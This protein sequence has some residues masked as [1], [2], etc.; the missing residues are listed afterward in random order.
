MTGTSDREQFDELYEAS[1][2]AVELQIR[3]V[4][5]DSGVTEDLLQETFLRA[6]QAR[7]TWPRIRSFRHWLLRIGTNLALNYL[8][9]RNRAKEVLLADQPPSEESEQSVEQAVADFT[10]PG[11]ES[12]FARKSELDLVR[13]LI[14]EL[15]ED[16][17]IVM[18]L[19]DQQDLSIREA[20]DALDIPGGTVKSRLHYGRR[21]LT[22]RLRELLDM[23]E[24]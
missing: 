2:H 3:R 13:K 21:R 19:V 5:R 15:P 22:G 20:S 23:E 6:W 16:K 14:A 7:D 4:V 12:V 18:E 10:N 17:R 11:P 8:R 24:P 1:A 9:S